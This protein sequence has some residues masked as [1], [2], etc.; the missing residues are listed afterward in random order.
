MKVFVSLLLGGNIGDT[1]SVFDRAVASLAFKPFSM[2][3][4]V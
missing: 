3:V 2:F 1:A 4:G